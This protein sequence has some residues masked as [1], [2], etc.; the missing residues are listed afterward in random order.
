MVEGAEGHPVLKGVAP[1]KSA[2]SLYKNPA[3]AGDATV[4]LTG[5]IPGHTEPVAWTRTYK[6]GRVFYTSLGH[7]RDFEDENFVRMVVNALYW[8]IHQAPAEGK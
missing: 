8:T 5:T 1:F 6:G 7:P 3:V 4:L 2:G